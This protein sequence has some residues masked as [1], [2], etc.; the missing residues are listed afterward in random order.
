LDERIEALK[1]R[2][3]GAGE[4]INKCLPKLIRLQNELAGAMALPE[5]QVI[6]YIRS[7]MNGQ[8]T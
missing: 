4:R 7:V 6:P 2:Y 5:E 1:K 3:P 8:N